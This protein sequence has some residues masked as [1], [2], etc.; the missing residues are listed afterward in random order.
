M[1]ID[2]EK[3]KCCSGENMRIRNFELQMLLF[4][5]LNF[6]AQCSAWEQMLQVQHNK[7]IA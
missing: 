5:Q 7:F 3:L 1:S 2:L 4:D 6:N